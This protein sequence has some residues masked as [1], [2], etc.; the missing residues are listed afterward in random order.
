MA[1]TAA[2]VTESCA[3]WLARLQLRP[4][5]RK[6]GLD[7]LAVPFAPFASATA[8]WSCCASRDL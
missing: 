7:Q 2:R 4:L 5:E 8:E 1:S 3:S 6:I